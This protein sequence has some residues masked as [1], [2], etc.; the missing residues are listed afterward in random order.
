MKK[1]L[2]RVDNSP[3]TTKRDPIETFHRHFWFE[4]YPEEDLEEVVEILGEDRVVFGSDWPHVEGTPEP[5]A[6]FD[7]VQ[8][9]SSAAL[10]KIMRENA[11][12][13]MGPL[14]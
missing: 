5:A 13:L 12:S 10:K 9:L 11:M 7:N 1:T 6:F 8:G 3:F 14:T 4:P 2:R